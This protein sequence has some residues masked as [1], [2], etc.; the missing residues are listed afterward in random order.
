MSLLN[1]IDEDLIKALKAG[2]KAMTT[3]LRGL[4]SDISYRRIEKREDLADDDVIA[5]L[6][7]AAKKRRESIEQF[8]TGNRMDLVEKESAELEV[9]KT[10]L[11]AQLS[12][13]RLRELIKNSIEETG[14]DSPA[15]LG[16]VMKE[17]MPRIR[18]RADGKLVNRLVSEMLSGGSS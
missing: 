13:E 1:K 18:G 7:S 17:L 16:I 5:V 12:E 4:K 2:D 15:K 14:A 3:L 9:I 6:N 8:Q 11:P 10:Y